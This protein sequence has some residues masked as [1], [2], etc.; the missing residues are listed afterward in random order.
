M[1]IPDRKHSEAH[2]RGSRVSA[3]FHG[4]REPEFKPKYPYWLVG[5]GGYT[6]EL[7]VFKF[8]V[9][10]TFRQHTAHGRLCPSV[11]ISLLA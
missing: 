9:W 8:Q 7:E 4:D 6:L 10:R 5:K 1:T 3:D 11:F 2:S